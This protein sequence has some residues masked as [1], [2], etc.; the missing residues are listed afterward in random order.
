MERSYL[1]SGG[2]DERRG[3]REGKGE[4]KTAMGSRSRLAGGVIVVKN[5]NGV[6]TMCVERDLTTVRKWK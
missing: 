1:V 4:T 5:V 6:W 3:W 2:V